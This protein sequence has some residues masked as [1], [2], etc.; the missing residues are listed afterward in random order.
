MKMPRRKANV[1]KAAI[2]NRRA[3]MAAHAL[4][5]GKAEEHQ[6]TLFIKWLVFHLCQ[7]H[8]EIFDPSNQ[9]A[10]AYAAGRRSVGLDILRTL[11][12]VPETLPD[13]PEE[14]HA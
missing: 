4:H 14:S 11:E 10:T 7:T 9:Y 5:R 13:K 6:Q 3:V 12:A 8:E 1:P 2:N